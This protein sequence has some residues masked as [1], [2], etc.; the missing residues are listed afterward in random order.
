MLRKDGFRGVGLPFKPICPCIPSETMSLRAWGDPAQP[1][2]ATY[3]AA[4][5]GMASYH[6]VSYSTAEK[7]S[8]SSSGSWCH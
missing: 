7:E 6:P 4:Y 5:H 1:S 3:A 2:A 8:V